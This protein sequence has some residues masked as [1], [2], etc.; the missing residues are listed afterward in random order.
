MPTRSG[1]RRAD[2]RVHRAPLGPGESA[3]FGG[4][5]CTSPARTIL[6][7]AATRPWDL[8]RSIREAGGQGMLDIAEILG[9]LDRYPGRRGCRRLRELIGER[10][11]IPEFTRSELEIRTYE[12]CRDAAYRVPAT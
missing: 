11:S 7:L 5:P 6:D 4:V 12:L 1:R 8:E 10:R 2:I 3:R 9:L